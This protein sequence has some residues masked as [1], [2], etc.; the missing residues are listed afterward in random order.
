MSLK[1]DP[2]TFQHHLIQDFLDHWRNEFN[3]P[4]EKQIGD[5]PHP[6]MTSS[7]LLGVENEYQ[8]L[9][10][11]FK[12]DDQIY[13]IKKPG[14]PKRKLKGP[15]FRLSY[16]LSESLFEGYALGLF[17]E[18]SMHPDRIQ[19]AA[20]VL[21]EDGIYI[22]GVIRVSS[23]ENSGIS[24]GRSFIFIF[25]REVREQIFAA[26]IDRR[27]CEKQLIRNFLSSTDGNDLSD[28]ILV[29]SEK[30]R[31]IENGV[32]F[33]RS[34]ELEARFDKYPKF[35]IEDLA[36][37]FPPVNKEGFHDQG[38]NTLF[39]STKGGK[40]A[41]DVALDSASFKDKDSKY[42][43]VELDPQK[44]EAEYLK[45]FM[46]SE[47]GMVLRKKEAMGESGWRCKPRDL[48]KL[49]L[50]IPT[51]RQARDEIVDG[52]RMARDIE[53]CVKMSRSRL[54]LDPD[55]INLALNNIRSLHEASLRSD[56]KSRIQHWLS[57]EE[58]DESINLEF[59]ATMSLDTKNW[60]QM[61]ALETSVLKTVAAFLNTG[62]GNLVI[63]I[64][65][66]T[67]RVLGIEEEARKMFPNDEEE[68]IIDN[69]ILKLKNWISGRFTPCVSH[70]VIVTPVDFQQS[71]V[72]H[73]KC[74]K[75]KIATIF[76]EKT[77]SNTKKDK[78]R[79]YFRDD[80]R[81]MT[82]NTEQDILSY[83]DDEGIVPPDNCENL[84]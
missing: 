8:L 10:A 57:C 21:Q 65:D 33:K 2:R 67:K 68:K 35:T 6:L 18:S 62:G 69:Y 51:D 60:S 52:V 40:A 56:L 83:C 36:V 23:D 7:E 41:G 50:P 77:S 49:L 45:C 66:S 46:D 42:L 55:S 71:T 3:H 14:L 73:V 26:E 80:N 27:T 64:E 43:R 48:K 39:I 13:T 11:E 63:G 31:G 75:S 70:L 24:C 16:R 84:V 76:T 59:K 4:N 54:V 53:N 58:I 12:Q 30:F 37:D 61:H 44:V 1:P 32:Y 25:S 9:L 38:R 82:K 79:F 29:P 34:L 15:W 78:Q 74:R 5:E 22:H 28:G 81:T 47:Y 19:D 72:L 17:H 20:Q